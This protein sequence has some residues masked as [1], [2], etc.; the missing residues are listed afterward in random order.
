MPWVSPRHAKISRNHMG[1]YTI[2]DLDSKEG[3]YLNKKKIW[4][5]VDYPLPDFSQIV[6]GQ[7]ISYFFLTPHGLF[8]YLQVFLE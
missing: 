4:P 3:T 2:T 7:A 8:E 1:L 6:F 5:G